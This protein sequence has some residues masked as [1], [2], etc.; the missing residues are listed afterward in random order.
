VLHFG[1]HVREEEHLAIAGAGDEGHFLALVD[2][3]EAKIVHRFLAA[4]VKETILLW[5]AWSM[6]R[7][8]ESVLGKC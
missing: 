1:H 3:L 6:E 2:D 5:V 4:H 8:G 7:V